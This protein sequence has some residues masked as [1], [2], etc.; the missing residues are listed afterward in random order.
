MRLHGT[1]CS[2]ML[3]GSKTSE[4]RV[5]L[6]R[7]AFI[8][9]L[10]VWCLISLP[11]LRIHKTLLGCKICLLAYLCGRPVSSSVDLDSRISLCHANLLHAAY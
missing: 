1:S 11:K 10:D 6:Y 9:V 8:L 4:S 2:I 5:E 7:L 3:T